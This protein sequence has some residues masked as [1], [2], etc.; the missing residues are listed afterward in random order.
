MGVALGYKFTK[1]FYTSQ[2]C[3]TVFISEKIPENEVHT[4]ELIPKVYSGIITDVI[5]V[6]GG[7]FP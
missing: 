6:F 7:I 3:I 1:G 5:A 4:N 2:K